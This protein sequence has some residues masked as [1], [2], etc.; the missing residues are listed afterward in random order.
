MARNPWLAVA[1]SVCLLGLGQFYNREYRK[2]LTFLLIA[3]LAA[4]G[5][6]YENIPEAMSVNVAIYLFAIWD[7][8]TVAKKSAQDP[9]PDASPPAQPEPTIRVF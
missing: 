6:T 8:Y 4:Y 5:Y 9:K 1:L 3:V 2:G 7:S